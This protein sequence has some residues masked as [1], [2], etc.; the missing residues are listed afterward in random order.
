MGGLIQ[1]SRKFNFKGI[2]VILFVFMVIASVLFVELSGVRANRYERQLLLLSVDKTHTK[3]EVCA[4][5]PKDTLLLRDSRDESSNIAY[6]QFCVSLD[7]MKTGYTVRDLAWEN[8]PDFTAFCEVIVLLADL[9][10]MG[11]DVVTLCEWVY[12]GGRAWFPMTLETNIYSSTIAQMIGIDA[13]ASNYCTVESIYLNE[14][15]MIGGGRAFAIT[16]PFESSRTVVLAGDE[17]TVY[18]SAN[19][20]GGVPLVWKTNY[21]DGTFVVDNIGIYDKAMRGFYA[22][23]YSL[24]SD[25]CV[26]PVIN[27]SAFYLDDFPSQIPSGNSEYIQ[28]DYQT[29]IRDFYINIWWP[30]MMNFADRFG[31]KYTGLAIESY[32]NAVDGT[33]DAVPDTGTFLNFGNMLL[34]KGGELGYHG[35]NHQ[36]LVLGNRDYKGHYDYKTWHSDVAM[37][38]AFDELV[39]LCDTLF[40][41]A[42]F[43]LYVPPSN[44]LSDEGREFLIREYPQIQ[45]ISGIYF[46]DI[47]D[48]ELDLGCTQEFNVDETGV[49]DQPR[50][51]SGFIM[52]NFMN[53]AA[54]S[55][56]NM[57]FVNTHFTHPDDALDPERGAELGWMEM[58]R[59]FNDYLSWLY[60]SAPGLRNLTGTEASAAVQRFIAA[61]PTTQVYESGVKIT[62]EHFHDEA[63]LLARFNEG[64]PGEI[65][66]GTMTHLTGGLYLI[67]AT[68]AVVDITLK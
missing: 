57:H 25:I 53:I 65:R 33:T 43:S 11:E 2:V 26:Y 21:G 3:E 60:T 20:A 48:A 6:E 27:A 34:R 64:V 35:Y 7:D 38:E 23:S 14:G 41:D 13:T 49:V 30:D 10:P 24:L 36:P 61:I 63:Q 47:A 19:Q 32:D 55:E 31:L 4:S 42:E 1:R 50:I 56:L 16:D 59:R 37:K 62:I 18:A 28:R 17:T 5:L 51:V 39:S 45:T 40:P 68:E 66:G 67:S 12:Q 29:T 58:K 15:F 8:V 44:L 52:D 22:A 54:V 9:T 46:D